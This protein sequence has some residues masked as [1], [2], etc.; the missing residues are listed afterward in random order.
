MRISISRRR[1]Q[2]GSHVR[3]GKNAR[4]SAVFMDLG[5]DG[6]EVCESGDSARRQFVSDAPAQSAGRLGAGGS[7]QVTAVPPPGRLWSRRVPPWAERI[8]LQSGS[9]RPLPV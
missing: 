8:S 2:S 7:T 6:D 1:E 9:P 5:E 4:K 3:K